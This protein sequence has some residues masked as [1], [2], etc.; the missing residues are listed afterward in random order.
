MKVLKFNLRGKTGFFK[1][2]EVN[3]YFYFTYGCI[4]KIALLGIFGAICG[5][6]GYNQQK[7][8]EFPEFYKKLNNIKVGIV[9]KNNKGYINKKV[10]TFNNSVGYASKEEG[11]N[12]IIK[13]QWLEDPEW[14]IYLKV[15]P[16]VEELCDRLINQKFVYIPYL[17]KNDHF[18][19]ISGVEVISKVQVTD[20]NKIDSLFL[21]KNIDLVNTSKLFDFTTKEEVFK[22]EEMLPITLDPTTNN[23]EL[24]TFIFTNSK[25]NSRGS[26]S[27]YDC[28]GKTIYFF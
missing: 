26:N 6:G 19:E 7:E 24:D 25:I 9:P 10:Q 15:G 21:S 12:L 14:E 13:E 4:H 11:G 22:Y 16:E 8:D 20:S 5:Y 27:I 23:Y 28:N 3:Q 1:N 18:A 2:P 17:G